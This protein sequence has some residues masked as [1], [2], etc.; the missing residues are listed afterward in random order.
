MRRDG[1]AERDPD[2]KVKRRE[3]GRAFQREGPMVAKDLVWAIAVLARGTKIYVC[4][5]VV[6][7]KNLIFNH[8]CSEGPG[9]P[10]L[11]DFGH[12]YLNL[13]IVLVFYAR[14]GC[15]TGQDDLKHF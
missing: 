13:L 9:R 2:S 14:N 11:L 12:I 6:N 10:L 15:V 7:L 1:D 4:Q 3:E 5:C 8:G